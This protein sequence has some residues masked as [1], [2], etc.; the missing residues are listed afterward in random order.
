M[1]SE[2]QASASTA[3]NRSIT[4]IQ[5]ENVLEDASTDLNGRTAQL[6]NA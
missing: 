2:Y 4:P 1:I 3:I 6:T 5:A